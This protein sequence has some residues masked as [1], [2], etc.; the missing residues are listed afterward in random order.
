MSR[1]AARLFDMHMCVVA[2]PPPAPPVP[3]PGVPNPISLPGAASVLI[4]NIPAARVTDNAALGVP[5]PII[6]GSTT[7]L[8]QNF[9]AARVGD[10]LACGGVIIPPCCPTVLI[11]G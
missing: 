6:M 3:P 11:G 1:P 7:V 2:A 10:Q 5:H 4:G 8:I 9:P